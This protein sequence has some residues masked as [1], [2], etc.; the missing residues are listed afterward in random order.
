MN[1]YAPFMD[2]AAAIDAL[3]DVLEL[4][5]TNSTQ[6]ML[7]DHTPADMARVATSIVL[8]DTVLRTVNAEAE[9]NDDA[10]EMAD[11]KSVV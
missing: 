6:E 7:S 8:E 1:D 4:W 11:R 10:A 2:P 9:G 3:V 5:V